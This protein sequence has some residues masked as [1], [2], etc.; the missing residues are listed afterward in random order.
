MKS[1]L[2]SFFLLL[3]ATT[4]S[5]QSQPQFQVSKYDTRTV[6]D[7]R[8]QIGLDVEMPDYTTK[9]VDADVIG[10]HLAKMLNLLVNNIA[11]RW[12]VQKMSS[13]LS[14][15]DAQ[16]KY[17]IVDKVK[18]QSISKRDNEIIVKLKT[19]LSPNSSGLKTTDVNFYFIDGVSDNRDVNDLFC[20]LS[21]YAQKEKRWG[22]GQ[23]P[24]SLCHSCYSFQ[25]YRLDGKDEN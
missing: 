19:W 14:S 2:F 10:D 5:A 12:Y 25:R 20:H 8:Q 11:D 23:F 13:I 24:L 6:E 1:I 4:L 3:G 7:L 16:L 15:Q 18:V 17:V 22:R 21:R 9:K